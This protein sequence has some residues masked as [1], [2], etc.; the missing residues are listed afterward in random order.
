MSLFHIQ[1]EVSNNADWEDYFEL[2][3][4]AGAVDLT[5][6]SFLMDV[7]KEGELVFHAATS[8]GQFVVID[9]QAGVCGIKVPAAVMEGVAPGL[10][11]CDCLMLETGR[12]L[13]LFTGKVLVK[14]GITEA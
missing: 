5:G 6:F 9:A 7:R 10:Y 12:V 3:D 8:N 4:E 14:Q 13:S 2:R 11:D 1:F